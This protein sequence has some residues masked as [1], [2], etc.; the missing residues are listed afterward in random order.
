[1]NDDSQKASS[2]CCIKLIFKSLSMFCL[3]I[4]TCLDLIS[5]KLDELTVKV[6]S[7]IRYYVISRG[8]HFRSL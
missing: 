2:T 7:S 4:T 3:T 1:M 8:M 6:S 5:I